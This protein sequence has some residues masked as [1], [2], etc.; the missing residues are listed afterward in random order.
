MKKCLQSLIDAAFSDSTKKDVCVV[1]ENCTDVYRYVTPKKISPE[2][3]HMAVEILDEVHFLGMAANV[4]NTIEGLSKLNKDPNNLF[5]SN[6]TVIPFIRTRYVDK[7]SGVHLLRTDEDPYVT[8]LSDRFEEKLEDEI[9]SVLKN[10]EYV[11]ISDYNKGL[12]DDKSLA[13]LINVAT[14]K[15]INT[16]IDSRKKN[17]LELL[18]KVKETPNF[19]KHVFVKLNEEEYLNQTQD[20]KEVNLIITLGK[21]G[22]KMRPG[23][24]EEFQYVDS[25]FQ[26][27]P[28][29]INGAGDTF[30]ACFAYFKE[31]LPSLEAQEDCLNLALLGASL[32][33]QKEGTSSVEIE[34]FEKYFKETE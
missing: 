18:G 31:R 11:I 25:K 26:V 12:I 23:N 1:G 17:I 14:K 20:L 22:C 3:P 27:V 4:L 7:K 2:G 9:Q 13:V 28:Q 5:V 16:Y 8:S 6:S 29:D 30:L 15:G 34:D 21:R 32:G 33:V 24:T 10:C 19:A